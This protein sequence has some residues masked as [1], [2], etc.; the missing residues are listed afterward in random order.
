MTKSRPIHVLR[1]WLRPSQDR[2]SLAQ[3]SDR[4][5]RQ[6]GISRTSLAYAAKPAVRQ[7]A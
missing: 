4:T 6:I 1:L 7:A 2:K 3:L 5:L